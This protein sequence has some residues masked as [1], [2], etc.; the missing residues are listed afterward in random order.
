MWG[1]RRDAAFLL[2]LWSAVVVSV[3]QCSEGSVR[4][5]NGTTENEGIVHICIDGQW[6]TACSRGWDIAE[7]LVT[8]RELGFMHG[9]PLDAYST[10]SN[11]D[12]YSFFC[13]WDETQLQHCSHFDFCLN[14][15]D[16]ARV[17]CHNV[18]ECNET[19]VRLV[20]G[21]TATKGRVQTCYNGFWGSV[22]NDEWDVRE[23]RVVCRQLGYGGLSFPKEY[24]DSFYVWSSDKVECKGNESK[25]SD[26]EHGDVGVHRCALGKSGVICHFRECNETDVRLVEGQTPHDGRIEICLDGGWGSVCYD[27]WDIGDAKVVCRQLGYDGLSLTKS[28]SSSSNGQTYSHLDDVDCNGNESKLSDCEYKEIS[29]QN[30]DHGGEPV[31]TCSFRE[32]NESDV[33]LVSGQTPHDGRVEICL[34]GGWTPVCDDRWDVREARVV[35]QQLGYEGP[36][37]PLLN[38]GNGSYRHSPHNNFM[39]SECGGEETDDC[40]H[41]KAGVICTTIDGSGCMEGTVHLVGSD[42]VSKGRVLYCHSGAWYAV[43]ADDWESTGEETR[44]LCESAGFNNPDYAS[45]LVNFG[46]GSSPLLPLRIRCDST[47]SAFSEC[48][49]G[50]V[51]DVRHCRHVAGVDCRAP[52]L[53]KGLTNCSKCSSSSCYNSEF[54]CSCDTNCFMYGNCCSDISTVVENCFVEE[55][56][57]GTVRLVGGVANSTGRLEFCAHGVWGRVCNA[58]GDWS[59]DNASLARVVCRAL[60]FSQYGAYVIDHSPDKYG[61]SERNA[62]IGEVRCVGTEVELLE[63]SH[64]SIGVH[65]CGYHNVTDPDIIISCFDE[66][67]GCENVMLGYEVG[68]VLTMAMLSFAVTE[69]GEVSVVMGWDAN[70]TR[71]VC[72]HLGFYSEDG[73]LIDAPPDAAENALAFLD[74]V[75]CTGSE[76]YVNECS[77]DVLSTAGDCTKTAVSC[78]KFSTAVGANRGSLLTWAVIGVAVFTLLVAFVAVI[79]PLL[80]VMS[81]KRHRRKQ[82]ERMQRDIM[83]VAGLNVPNL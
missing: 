34:H 12:S 67:R 7:I 57:H 29:G 50:E 8:C 52:C 79:V 44:V 4:L 15:H 62:V 5:I 35:C 72:R 39:L 28:S 21:E 46:R 48:S 58:L 45:V 68:R 18:S 78:R 41:G 11:T 60:G 16:V 49:K 10:E 51:L 66:K 82:L 9:Y 56:E 74:P 42:D 37:Y 24:E 27:Q 81:S 25:L 38:H 53:T 73:V 80:V 76:R 26:C 14:S 77:H 54:K 47:Q 55:C 61:T 3:Q 1:L 23:A 20:Q 36:S 69:Y 75:T 22:C 65:H 13:T 6:N 17:K 32:C 31:V 71:V 64:S 43:C 59:L 30:C 70:D 2:L 40:N 83:A 19:D 63:C 33:R